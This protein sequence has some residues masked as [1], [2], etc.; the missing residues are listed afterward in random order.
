MLIEQLIDIEKVRTDNLKFRTD[1]RDLAMDGW[2]KTQMNVYK[3]ELLKKSSNQKSNS[4]CQHWSLHGFQN[5]AFHLQPIWLQILVAVD[6]DSESHAWHRFR[7]FAR[8]HLKSLCCLIRISGSEQT[9][10]SRTGRQFR[11]AALHCIRLGTY[12][13]V[14]MSWFYSETNDD[15]KAMGVALVGLLN[16]VSIRVV[17]LFP[18][19]SLS[20]PAAIAADLETPCDCER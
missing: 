15:R 13:F 11:P 8:H 19:A 3:D 18:Q 7:A 17:V 12:C 16:W 9:P 14:Q 6:S 5:R 2:S 20:L 10:F 1:L 4:S